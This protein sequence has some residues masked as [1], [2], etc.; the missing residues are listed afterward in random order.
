M[1]IPKLH[2]VFTTNN[3]YELSRYVKSFLKLEV[4]KYQK[5]TNVLV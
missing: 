3:R 2:F 4:E 5:I 1:L